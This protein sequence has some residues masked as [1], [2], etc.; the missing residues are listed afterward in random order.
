MLFDFT[1][2]V[3]F[4]FVH[5]TFAEGTGL[6]RPRVQ[7][8]YAPYAPIAGDVI[9]TAPLA[10]AVVETSFRIPAGPRTPGQPYTIQLNDY[11]NHLSA[12]GPFAFMYCRFVL[13]DVS[14]GVSLSPLWAVGGE[15]ARFAADRF[16]NYAS[17]EQIGAYL[18]Q[19]VRHQPAGSERLLVHIM[20]GGN[21][22]NDNRAAFDE[23]GVATSLRSS[24]KTGHKLNTRTLITRIRNAWILRGFDP[25][26]LHF[27][28]GPYHP[29][30][31]S[32]PRVRY[33][34]VRAWRELA[35]EH[36]E[37]N[38]TVMDGFG[39]SSVAQF[40]TNSWYDPASGQPHLSQ[41]G[42][43]GYGNLVWQALLDAADKGA[44]ACCEPGACR[45][46]QPADCGGAFQGPG[47]VC[48]TP[49]NPIACCPA[50]FN[51]VDGLTVQD[52]FDFLAAYF[53][54]D[55]AAD[56]NASGAVSVQDIFDYLTAYFT[57]C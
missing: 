38:I 55:P 28:L 53:L 15:S 44:G 30:N 51:A 21:D 27:L 32:G 34:Y 33:W 9:V 52:L 40:I 23:N 25:S 16:T 29:A 46:S 10:D 24:S 6:I 50:N 11:A 12:E 54:Q 35:M 48:G 3:D 45:V 20:E 56:I 1:R 18:R 31:N 5:A 42:Y 26:R 36:P 39:V 49:S 57:G 37:W 13:P 2:D 41:A 17:L 4:H 7:L 22:A 43:I 14:T 19:M 47:S 8:Y